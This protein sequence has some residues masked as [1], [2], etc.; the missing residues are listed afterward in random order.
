MTDPAG[1]TKTSDVN[2]TVNQ[3]LT[4]IRNTGQ[5]SAGPA[6]DQF[7]N[8]LANQPEFDEDSDT[9]TDPLT[10]DANVT[11][12]PAAGTQLTISGGINGAGG[13]TVNA[14]GI[15][16]LSGPNGYT[17]GTKVSAGTL[18]LSNSASIAANTSLTVARAGSSSSILRSGQLHPWPLL[19]R[20]RPIQRIRPLRSP[21][22]CNDRRRR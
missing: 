9:I 3:V 6:F 10:F 5:P 17:G 18:L 2:V 21:H 20:Y 22:G 4:S 11:V 16:I 13:P 15:V 12:L 19:P 14:P 1:L 8:P 7:G